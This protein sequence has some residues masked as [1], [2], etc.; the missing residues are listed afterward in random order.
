VPKFIHVSAMMADELSP[1][2]WLRRKAQGEAAVSALCARAVVSLVMLASRRP[3]CMLQEQ[4]A[5]LGCDG[6]PGGGRCWRCT[7]TPPFS[8]PG[9]DGCEWCSTAGWE[10][11]GH[12]SMTY[13]RT[14]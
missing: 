12:E 4:W 7:P 10:E 14:R 2:T 1:S 3:V 8:A 9:E 11:G 5:A 13:S 6:H